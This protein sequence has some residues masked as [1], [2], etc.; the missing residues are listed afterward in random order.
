MGNLSRQND[1]DWVFGKHELIIHRRYEFFYNLNDVLIALWFLV[2]SILFFWK[3]TQEAGTWLFV[4]GS[5][6]LLVRPTIRIIRKVHLHRLQM[7]LQEK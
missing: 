3:G 6:Q 7:E 1:I 5:I 4:V 2:G